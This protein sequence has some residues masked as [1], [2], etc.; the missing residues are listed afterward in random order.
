LTIVRR[1]AHY[2]PMK[3]TSTSPKEQSQKLR[4][5]T[6]SI[7]DHN[8]LQLPSPDNRRVFVLLEDTVI[9]S[10]DGVTSLPRR[11]AQGPFGFRIATMEGVEELMVQFLGHVATTAA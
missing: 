9:S 8:K 1:I 2:P 7:H 5:I 11:A 4:R 3:T 10:R 6:D